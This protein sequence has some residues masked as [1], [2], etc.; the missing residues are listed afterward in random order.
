RRRHTRFSRDWSSDVCSSDLTGATTGAGQPAQ[1][2]KPSAIAGIAADLV[3]FNVN[4]NAWI[5]SMLVSK[6][7]LFGIEWRNTPF[8]DNKAARSEERRVGKAGNYGWSEGQ[9]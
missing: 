4:Q 3:D 2:C 9:Y 1:N 5:S 7:G 8:F 6:A